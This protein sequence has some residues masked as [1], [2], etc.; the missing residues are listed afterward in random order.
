VEIFGL[1]FA[2]IWF[3]ILAV[4]PAAV[5]YG[6]V[7]LWR[8]EKRTSRALPL[9]DKVGFA[10]WGVS[11]VAIA[12]YTFYVPHVDSVD[13]VKALSWIAVPSDQVKVLNAETRMEDGFTGLFI[14][15]NSDEAAV[16]RIAA[17]WGSTPGR[18]F[19]PSGDYQGTKPTWFDATCPDGVTYRREGFESVTMAWCPSRKRVT[20]FEVREEPFD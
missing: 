6:V 19:A 1:I 2:F 3:A 10:T 20:F 4:I 18:Y 17:G 12:L 8:R 5:A 14:L 13:G 11:V 9:A 15:A 7:K 16:Q